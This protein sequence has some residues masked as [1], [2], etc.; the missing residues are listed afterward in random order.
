MTQPE[1][2]GLLQEPVGNSVLQPA[3]GRSSEMVRMVPSGLKG[4]EQGLLFLS[5]PALLRHPRP[6][7]RRDVKSG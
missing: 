7:L 1:A 4:S 2:L 6:G 5:S 3:L